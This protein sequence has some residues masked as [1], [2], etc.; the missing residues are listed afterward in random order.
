MK[1]RAVIENGIGETRAAVYEGR[2]LVELHLERESQ[3]HLPQ[4]GD[5]YR[6][7][8][9]NLEPSLNGAFVDLGKN[10][11]GFLSFTNNATMPRLIEG[12][13]AHLVVTRPS[14]EDKQTTL[15]FSALANDGEPGLSKRKPLKERL[16]ARFAGI[17]F[18]EASVSVID[19]AVER[20]IALKG[21]GSVTFDQT[22]AL[23]AIDVDKGQGMTSLSVSLA[24]TELIASQMRLR[25]LGGLVVI[26]FPNLRQTRQRNQLF[27]AVERAFEDD[28]SIV[29][30]APLSRFGCVELT[31][32]LDYPSL[33]SIMNNRFGDLTAETLALRALRQL[34][35]EALANRGAQLT[36]SISSI[37]H[38]WLSQNVIDWKTALSERIGERYI[39]QKSNIDTYA[40]QADR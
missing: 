11:S 8:I 20:R 7:R 25:G 18:D 4:P 38:D 39:V 10:R 17:S 23:L 3:A 37:I 2:K 14:S 27:K 19:D 15:R 36:L 35:R 21:G 12:Q 24:A 32:S 31:R 5:E 33:D 40:V 13:L 28:P 16:E 9:K 22:Q 6:G 30:V 1:R 26:D 29:K 34:E